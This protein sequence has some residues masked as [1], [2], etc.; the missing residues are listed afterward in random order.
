MR[1]L[2]GALRCNLVTASPE[3]NVSSIS[4]RRAHALSHERAVKAVNAMAERLSEEYAVKSRWQDS[5][6]HFDR[7]GLTGTLHLAAKEI[8]LNV[9]LGFLLGAFREK[10]AKEIERTLDEEL[11]AKP[12]PVKRREK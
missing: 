6:L 2:R 10:I 11:A 12:M 5:T 4:I 3:T 7:V 9:Q 8:S 1:A